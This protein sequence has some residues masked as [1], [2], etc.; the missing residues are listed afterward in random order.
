MELKTQF[1]EGYR[2]HLQNT[3]IGPDVG[4][5]TERHQ[6]RTVYKTPNSAVVADLVCK[7]ENMNYSNIV[8]SGPAM[9]EVFLRVAKEPQ[10]IYVGDSSEHIEAAPHNPAVTVPQSP[11]ELENQLSSSRDTSFQR[12]VRILLRKRYTILRR[13]WW[14][15]LI[16]LAMPLAVTPNLK[17]FLLFYNIPS[18]LDLTADV[19][20]PEPFNFL[21]G[22]RP[23]SPW[24]QMVVGPASIN[25]TLYD[26]V[27]K[28]PVGVGINPQNYSNE[29]VFANNFTSFQDYVSANQ[30][31]II[32]G[33]LYMDNNSSSPTYAYIGDYGVFPALLMQNLWT[34]IRSGILIEGY[35]SLFNSL[36]SVRLMETS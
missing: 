25:E 13:N 18:C 32:P 23:I 26:A 7:L 6:H 3:K 22:N 15:Y 29:F 34:Q 24:T 20:T 1:G 17:S 4:F 21:L 31:N 30:T 36:I 5:E 10:E 2:V 28:L 16:V 12:Q 19:H 9:E 8:I 11:L 33:A 27:T 35:F 14:P